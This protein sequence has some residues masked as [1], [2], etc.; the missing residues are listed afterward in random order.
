MRLEVGQRREVA[1]PEGEPVVVVPDVE[2]VAQAI[3]QPI[4]KAEVAAVG[5]APDPGRLERHPERLAQRPLDLELDLLPAGL[6][7][8]QQELLLGGQELPVEKVL[9]LPA[10]HREEL[11]A[12]LEPQLGC[13][14]I[15]M[16]CGYSNHPAPLR[17]NRRLN[18][19]ETAR[20]DLS[21]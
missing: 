3:G 18:A 15:G 6:A 10:V 1:V 11:G 12:F 16:Y 7:H 20:K 13:D 4:H 21:L 8:V 9:Q 14:R 17:A 19:P 2:H 5:A